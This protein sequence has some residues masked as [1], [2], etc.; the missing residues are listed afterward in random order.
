MR[1]KNGLTDSQTKTLSVMHRGHAS[2]KRPPQMSLRERAQHLVLARKFLLNE[3]LLVRT[4]RARRLSLP[5]ITDAFDNA[6]A[7]KLTAAT[8]RRLRL[9]DESISVNDV[10]FQ[11]QIRSTERAPPPGESDFSK[12]ANALAS[13]RHQ[14]T[15]TTATML[16]ITNNTKRTSRTITIGDV[17]YFTSGVSSI[18]R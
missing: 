16:P 18:T 13:E 17:R 6:P 4:H 9:P 15:K 8:D 2:A 10:G 7:R 14:P 3:P 1:S 5:A 11:R 12:N